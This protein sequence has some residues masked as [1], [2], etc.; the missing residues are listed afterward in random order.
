MKTNN[1]FVRAYVCFIVFADMSALRFAQSFARTILS[2]KAH[3]LSCVSL[4]DR[5]VNVSRSERLFA[6]NNHI[7]HTF[8][9]STSFDSVKRACAA[10]IVWENRFQ[11]LCR[12]YI[13]LFTSERV[14]HLHILPHTNSRS[15][16]SRI[17]A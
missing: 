16:A 9:L 12:R 13:D 11:M 14:T 3:F 1:S 10:G 2:Q 15:Y 5:R 4:K 6:F 7:N 17:Y 8:S